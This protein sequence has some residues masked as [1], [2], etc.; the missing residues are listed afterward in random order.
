MSIG[1]HN[2][3]TVT[4]IAINLIINVNSYLLLENKVCGKEKTIFCEINYEYVDACDGN[5]N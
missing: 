5:G 4:D 3:K 2:D 1:L